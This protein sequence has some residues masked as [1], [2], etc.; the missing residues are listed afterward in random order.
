[1]FYLY[2]RTVLLLIFGLG[3]G[4]HSA[5]ANHLAGGELTYRYLDATGP[6]DRPF[7]YEITASVYYDQSSLP[8][9][10]PNIPLSFISKTDRSLLFTIPL[11]R[12]TNEYLPQLGV[13]GCIQQQQPDIT[14]ARYVTTVNLPAVAEGYTAVTIVRARSISV[15]NIQDPISQGMALFMD[16][17]PGGLP[18]SS[19]VFSDRAVA[20]ICFGDTSLELN[21]A[22]DADGDRLSYR[23][24]T[25]AGNFNNSL[26]LSPVVYASGYAATAPF[27]PTGFV[28]LDARTG[29]ARYRS[30]TQGAFLLAVDVSEYRYLN[31]REV[32]LGTVR[33]DIQVVVRMCTGPANQAPGFAATPA[34]RDYQ[35]TQGQTLSLP[36]RAT[37]P[38]GQSLTLAVSSVL[39][40]G[41]GPI[42]ASVNGLPGDGSS[43]NAVGRVQVAG[44]GTVTAN[45]QLQ[46]SCALARPEP[47]DVIATATDD[48]CNRKSA[49]T[50]FRVTVLQPPSVV[51]VVGDSVVC[52]TGVARYTAV[53]PPQ[54]SY[55]WAVEGGQVVGGATGQTLQVQWGRLGGVGTVSVRSSLGAGC[56]TASGAMVVAIEPGLAVSG[57]AVY[58]RKASTGLRYQVSGPARAYAWSISGGTIA[59]G[60]GTNEVVVDVIPGATASLRVVSPLFPGC[61]GTAVQISPDNTCLAFYNVIT[62]N[63]DGQNDVFTVEN[64]ERYPHTDLTVYNRWGRQVYHSANYGNTYGGEGASAGVY[65]YRCQLANGT[66]YKGWFEIVR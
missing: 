53:G 21:N 57:P 60:Q 46:S 55:Q 45:F 28:A 40:D 50:V 44:T 9:G 12:T 2:L 18:N 52:A 7:R 36:I 26:T 19:P 49:A 39:L 22:Y 8:S 5:T 37:D 13:P 35:I 43:T 65:Y 66:A 42:Q 33:R 16:M 6:A 54:A 32:L 1:M 30:L 62:P 3:A 4:L 24:A 23:L 10:D 31:G 14:L 11:L 15:S 20:Q 64:V 25:P 51:R 41:A 47:Y 38:E 48:A 56:F 59:S 63:G 27:G 29:L 34:Q 17:T 58:C 61:A